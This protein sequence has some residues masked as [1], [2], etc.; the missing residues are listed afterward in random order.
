MDSDFLRAEGLATGAKVGAPER[1]LAQNAS[2]SLAV[3]LLPPSR[4]TGMNK[5]TGLRRVGFL[6]VAF[7]E[8]PATGRSPT[9]SSNAALTGAEGVR[10][11][12]T[13]MQED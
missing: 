11:E 6:S 4:D 13:V 7:F 10:V 5:F 1:H 3:F 12:G 8:C 9:M 2:I